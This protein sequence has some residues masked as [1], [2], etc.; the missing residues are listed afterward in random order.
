MVR[1][2]SVARGVGITGARMIIMLVGVAR[3]GVFAGSSRSD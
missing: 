1:V 3:L 2:G